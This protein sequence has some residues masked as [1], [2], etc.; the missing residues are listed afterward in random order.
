MDKRSY[1]VVGGE[2]ADTSFS[3]LVEGTPEERFGPFTESGAHECWRALTGKT[4]DNAMVRYFV[5][6]EDD[7][8]GKAFFVV[9]GE[10]AGTDFKTMA[11]G[12]SVERYGPFE[13]QEAMIF[14]RGITSQTVDSALHRYDIVSDREIDDFL[15]R[16]AAG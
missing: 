4:V 6:N 5:R 1:W 8:Q 11:E 16:F 15:G 3:A 12:H 13:K 10:Y 14:W 9:G 2:Y 7:R